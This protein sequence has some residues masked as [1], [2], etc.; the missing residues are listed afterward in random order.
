MGEGRN[1]AEFPG[2][3]LYVSVDGDASW[4]GRLPKPSEDGRDGPLASLQEARD[5]IRKVKA[6]E[7]L[8]AGGIRVLVQPGIY[9]MSETLAFV[10]ED[11]GTAERPI[12]YVAQGDVRIIGGREIRGFEPM[13]DAS[14]RGRLS[15]DAQSHVVVLDLAQANI[16]DLGEIVHSGFGRHLP[17][18]H[19]ELFFNGLPMRL[20]EWPNGDWAKV[21]WVPKGE[22]IVDNSGKRRG[23]KADRFGF[24][25]DQP[26]SW[27]RTDDVWVHGY[28]FVNWAD[29]YLKVKSIDKEKGAVL[30]E[31]PQSSYG[32][33][34]GQRFRFLNVLEELD[35]PG[36][37]YV[38]RREM[39]LTF[40]PPS[41]VEDG[42]AMV[43]VLSEPLASFDHASHIRLVDMTFEC[44]R[45]DGIVI[46]EGRD[47]LIAGCTVRNVG[48]TAVKVFEGEN[49][50]IRSCDMSH[51]GEGGIVLDGGDR[52]TLTPAGHVADNNHIHHFSR[53]VRTYRVGIRIGG[54]GNQASHNYI[55]DA[56]HAGITYN[57]NNHVVEYNELTRLCLDTGDVGGIYTGRDWSA[58]GSV[59]RYNYI[60]RLGGVK[61]NSN[62]IYLDDLASG[63]TITGNIL[64]KVHRG[65]M[66]GGGRDNVVENNIFFDFR[67]GVH[68]DARGIGW[69]RKLIEGRQGGW[70]MFGRLEKMPYDKPPYS[71]QYPE[72]AHIMEDDPLEPRR[73]RIARNIFV[74]KKWLDPIRITVEQIEERNFAAFEDNLMDEDPLFI[75]PEAGNFSLKEGSPALKLGF[76]AIPLEDIGLRRD[77]Y[78]RT[79]QG[80]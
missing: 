55:H 10:E 46:R 76:E 15:E 71:D 12:T 5:A 24:E 25:G 65:M 27:K 36:E 16:A 23:T 52:Q 32:Y 62:A 20:A 1:M 70:D 29:Q 59:L 33:K 35:Q 57:G 79:I 58:Q 77:A 38:D 54:V 22:P 42:I 45:S 19:M 48:G 43:S 64:H 74:G 9:G 66:I 39:K 17:L 2:L 34:K 21:A 69:S 8:P 63:Q 60:H 30:I 14:V 78:R 40:W 4:S 80:R 53:W 50:T 51:M 67:I 28:W 7:G 18:S 37:Y 41:P 11:S 26:K 56:P 6:R 72:L 13:A 31:D 44:G 47:V 49:H 68:L 73:N 61:G 3:N 75:D